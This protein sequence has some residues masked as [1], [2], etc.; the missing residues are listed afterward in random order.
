[1]ID[2]EQRGTERCVAVKGWIYEN[3]TGSS[4]DSQYVVVLCPGRVCICCYERNEDDKMDGVDYE[5]VCHFC[6]KI[7]GVSC[8][9]VPVIF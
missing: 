7:M 6:N 1:M 3:A 5:S 2:G 8:R 4:V 9:S